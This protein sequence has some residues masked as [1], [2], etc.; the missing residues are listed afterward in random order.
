MNR[1]QKRLSFALLPALLVGFTLAAFQHDWADRQLIAA[2]NSH[3]APRVEALLRQGADPD[4]RDWQTYFYQAGAPFRPPWYEKYLAGLT[5]REPRPADPYVG[6][7]AL[8]IA[9]GHGD[10]AVAQSLLEHGA[11]AATRGTD[12][13]Y[14]YSGANRAVV[15]PLWEAVKEEHLP[16]VKMLLK[17][18][19]AAD[20]RGNGLT[21]LMLADGLEIASAL[22]D[23]G[24]DVNATAD[25]SAE[26]SRG[27]TPLM[28]AMDTPYP[29]HK[30]DSDESGARRVAMIRLLLK[31][32][33]N[34]NGATAYGQTPLSI[35]A[36][37]GWYAYAALL[38]AQGADPNARD[39]DGNTSLSAAASEGQYKDNLACL[40]LLAS[41]G[42]DVNSQNKKGQTA[43]MLASHLDYAG[44]EPDWQRR[45][46]A[47]IRLLRRF[48]A[49]PRLK[50]KQGKTAA[51]YFNADPPDASGS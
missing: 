46:R 43:L 24:A 27:L 11:N 14:D 18:K 31:R 19:A 3:D 25:A 45:R 29:L 5:H 4:T 23:A 36:T 40:R 9:A 38:L 33:A 7:T 6:P 26:D 13:E 20:D 15:T 49:D 10:I 2:V 39:Q 17:W 21:P 37:N 34:I 41:Y 48:G 1:T 42:A 44:A 22:I 50:D 47:K 12:V 51:D 28:F 16:V 32:G 8:M 30:Y 35:A